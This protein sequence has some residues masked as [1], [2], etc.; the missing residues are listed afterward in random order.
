MMRGISPVPPEK[1]PRDSKG[2]VLDIILHSP[3]SITYFSG[4]KINVS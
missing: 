1:Y 2:T 4:L 3:L